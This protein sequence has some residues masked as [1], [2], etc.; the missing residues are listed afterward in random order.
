MVYPWW[1]WIGKAA[2]V[3]SLLTLFAALAAWRQIRKLNSRYQALWIRI[4]QQLRDLEA[5]AYEIVEAAPSATSN[6]DA[7][8]NALS[9]AEGKL[10]SLEGWIG[11]RYVPFS[12]RRGLV[13]EIV[14]VRNELKSRQARGA[15][16]DESVARDAYRKVSKVAQL[17]NDHVEDRR[18][19]R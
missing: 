17:I 4:P 9:A 18:L 15:R 3:L 5:A 12:R 13:L 1:E 2:D 11:G 8:L 10:T 6:P 19:E 14:K 7:V 16:L